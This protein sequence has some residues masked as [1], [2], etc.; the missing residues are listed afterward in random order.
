MIAVVVAFVA[1][2]LL[3]SNALAA[4]P[5]LMRLLVVPSAGQLSLVI[6]MSDETRRVSTQQ[7][8]ATTLLLDAG[9]VASPLQRQVLNAPSGLSLLQQ[10]AADE[11]IN[12]EK[13]HLL[14]LRITMKQPA[15]N[16]VRV[17]GR[18][19]YVDFMMPD[20]PMPGTMSRNA[21]AGSS[22]QA[23]KGVADLKVNTPR[24]DVA[25]FQQTMNGAASQ[26]ER[27]QPFLLSATSSR[28]SNPAVLTAVGEAISGL[29]LSLRGVRPPAAASSSSLQLLTSAVSTAAQ[30][31][32]AD[33]Q[34]D[35]TAKARQSVAM[36]AEAKA[37]LQ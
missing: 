18:R 15:P 28:T 36:F 24:A 34:G 11:W 7:T 8:T 16:S 21:A 31:V 13:E 23:Q 27:I 32:S 30:A 2:L 25:A 22:P 20:V 33:F 14:R 35:R 9:P 26:F 4:D 6:E 10:V 19:I 17:V 29:Q 12:D 37:Q 5:S 3:P 1:L